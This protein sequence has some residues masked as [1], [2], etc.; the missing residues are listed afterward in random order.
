MKLFGRWALMSCVVS[1]LM[2]AAAA[3]QGG[4]TQQVNVPLLVGGLLM[5]G[6]AGQFFAFGWVAE[7]ASRIYFAGRDESVYA[8]RHRWG[9]RESVIPADSSTWRK[10]G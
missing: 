4:L 3:V 2:L 9:G 6:L 7:V 10:A 1:F 5:G 8:V